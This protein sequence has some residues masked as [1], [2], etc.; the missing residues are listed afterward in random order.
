[1]LVPVIDKAAD[2]MV[3]VELYS[4][5]DL[6]T[7]KRN[8]WGIPEPSLAERRPRALDAPSLT[9]DLIV[10]PGL[11]FDRHGHRLGHGKGYYD[12]FHQAC[13]L[14]SQ[15][16]SLPMPKFVAIALTQQLAPVGHELPHEATDALIDGIVTPDQVL[17]FQR[18]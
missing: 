10:T 14:F 4:L 12:R 8:A 18:L 2:T 9:L 16:H 7:C 11:F 13:A 1:V 15:S 5:A 17:Q 6:D 3:M